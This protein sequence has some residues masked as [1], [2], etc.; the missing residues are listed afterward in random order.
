MM[1]TSDNRFLYMVKGIACI[2]VILIHVKFPGNLGTISETLARFAVPNNTD[3]I[4]CLGCIYIIFSYI[5]VILRSRIFRL[6]S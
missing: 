1:D 6:D 2:M 5:Y 4:C 3:Y